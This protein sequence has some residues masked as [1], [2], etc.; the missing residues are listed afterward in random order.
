MLFFSCDGNWSAG[1]SG[2][3]NFDYNLQG[4]WASNE[5]GE[6]SG[7]LV[8]SNSAITISGYPANNNYE[9]INGTGHRPFKDFTKNAP[10]EGYTEE[11]RIFIKDRG[12]IQEGLPYDVWDAD[13]KRIYFL[14]FN[15]GG[16]V[17]TL[18]KQ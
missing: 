10:L 9:R 18:R 14:S 13:N 5:T 16:R 8:I 15:F 3:K 6:Y 1:G 4:T 12:I 17:E 2:Y 11:G 7:T